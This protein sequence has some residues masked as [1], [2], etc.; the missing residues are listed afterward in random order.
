MMTHDKVKKLEEKG[1][2]WIKISELLDISCEEVR[3]LA[4]K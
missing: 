3:E 4:E 2:N 1:F